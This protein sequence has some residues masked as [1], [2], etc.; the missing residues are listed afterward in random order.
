[1]NRRMPDHPRVAVIADI[2]TEIGKAAALLLAS[3]GYRLVLCSSEKEEEFLIKLDD[4]GC[5]YGLAS[6]CFREEAEVR[7]LVRDVLESEIFGRIDVFFYNILPKI[8][9]GPTSQLSMEAF[10]QMIDEDIT[11]AMVAAKTM[12][13][14]LTDASL[15]FLGSVHGDKPT[16]AAPLYSMY[17]GALKN[18]MSEA[19]FHFGRRRVRCNYIELGAMGGEDRIFKNPISKFYE[20]YPYKIPTGHVP[21]EYDIAEIVSFLGSDRSEAVNGEGIRADG[22]L[23]LEYLDPIANKNAHER[24]DG[25]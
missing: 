12:G 21:T 4:I 22:G 23:I 15:I 11:S 24:I 14:C 7:E 5:V 13:C 10:T 2:A 9:K 6:V 25:K 3:E 17:M 20:G 16:G 18:M 19:A 8:R 1:M